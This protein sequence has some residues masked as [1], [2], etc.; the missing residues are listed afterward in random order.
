MTPT[1]RVTLQELLPWRR[2][3]QGGGQI[4]LTD[5]GIR[6]MT[7]GAQ[8]GRYSNA[9][10]DNYGSMPRALLPC[11]PPLRL[12]LRAR[13]PT[14]LLGTAGFGFWNSPISPLGSPPALPAALW[15][16]HA[17]PPSQIAPALDVPGHGWKAATIDAGSASARRWIPAAPIVV[18]L[19]RSRALRRRIWPRVQR[20]LGVAEAHLGPP[21][22]AW[23]TYTIEWR[24]DGARLLIDD[25]VVLATDH[26]PIGPLGFVAWV[27]TQWLVATPTAQLG[28]GLLDAPAPQWIDLDA[29]RIAALPDAGRA[30]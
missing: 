9:Q 18:L 7:V 3:Q 22:P 12:T 28:W 14:P 4:L 10:I 29:I 20:A 24:L 1:A 17:S 13:M 11:R 26:A 8:R 21:S 15:F 19:N 30:P 6:L 27:D 2:L 25:Q 5:Q 16:F 23:R